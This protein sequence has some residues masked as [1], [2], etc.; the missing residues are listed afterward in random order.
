MRSSS[1]AFAVLAWLAAPAPGDASPPDTATLVV[2]ATY[3]G[4]SGPLM[5]SFFDGP[6]GYPRDPKKA[7]YRVKARMDDGVGQHTIELPPGQ[8]GVAAWLDADADEEM[9]TNWLGVPSEPIG[10]LGPKPTLTSRATWEKNSVEVP[11]EGLTVR[12]ELYT[13]F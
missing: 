5:L 11:A 4:G 12:I 8:W 13:I 3:E 9:D 2:V 6:D 10:M 1:A 7:R